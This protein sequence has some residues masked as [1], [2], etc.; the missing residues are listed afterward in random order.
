MNHN[1]H[2][3]NLHQRQQR[4]TAARPLRYARERAAS[5]AEQLSRRNAILATCELVNIAVER[6]IHLCYQADD[7]GYPSNVDRTT[8]RIEIPCPWGRNG[9]SAHGLRRTESDVLRSY[10]FRLQEY[11]EKTP[12]TQ[13]TQAPLF[14]YDPS[15]RRWH[16]N[17]FD[18]KQLTPALQ[19]WKATELTPAIWRAVIQKM[20]KA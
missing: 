19:Y 13:A 2:I 16:L 15:A 6:H 17:I 7:D 3:T 5:M 9:F 1:G 8:G 11:A 20:R 12:A 14:T 4:I 10:L 18:H